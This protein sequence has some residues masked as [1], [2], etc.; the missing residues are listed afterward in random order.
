VAGLYSS[1]VILFFCCRRS[2]IDY[3]PEVWRYLKFIGSVIVL[4][5]L[6]FKLVSLSLFSSSSD[7]SLL[8]S[9]YSFLFNILAIQVLWFCLS[10]SRRIESV[11]TLDLCCSSVLIWQ[12]LGKV[13][14]FSAGCCA[15]TIT[16]GGLSM[17]LQL[18]EACVFLLG[19]TVLFIVGRSVKRTGRMGL[20][21][22][23]FYCIE[24]FTTEFY[25]IDTGD[26][27]I[28]LTLYQYLSVALLFLASWSYYNLG[29]ALQRESVR[30]RPASFGSRR[31][32]QPLR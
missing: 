12:S 10:V 2:G 5:A 24:R 18:A 23:A 30:L 26:R 9:E 21:F 8:S 13:G 32:V 16:F 11:K 6:L 1:L 14:C 19:G 22:I 29:K 4:G 28:G 27:V 15:G 7:V 25:R 3:L 20:Y 31:G 17:P